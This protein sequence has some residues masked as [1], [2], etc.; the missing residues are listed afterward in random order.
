MWKRSGRR[1]AEPWRIWPPV[2]ALALVGVEALLAV[3]E[4]PRSVLSA[5]AIVVAP[6]LALQPFLPRELGRLGRWLVVPMVGAAAASIAIIFISAIGIPLT[7][8]SLRLLLAVIALG[9]LVVALFVGPEAPGE[10]PGDEWEELDGSDAG[11]R[12]FWRDRT[13]VGAAVGL[14]A[15]LCLAVALQGRVISGSPVPGPDWGSHLLY[16]EQIARQHALLIDNPYW[17]LGGHRFSSDPGVAAIYGAFLIM[18][19]LSATVLAHGIWVF[20]LLSIVAVFVL[21][22]SLWGQG[23]GL[24]AAGVY[25]VMPLNHN[26]LGWHGLANMYALCLLPLTLLAAGW[27]LRGR[28][29]ARWSVLMALTLV[30]LAAGHRL[31]FLLAC[32]AVAIIA[33]VGLVTTPGR[34]ALLRFGLRTAAFA[35]PLVALVAI[36]LATRSSDSG[37]FQSYEIYLVTKV[38]WGL[39]V[40]DLTWPVTVAA[41]LGAIV[42]AVRSRR[43]PACLVLLGLAAATVVLAYGWLLHLPTVYYRMVYYLP[44]AMAPAVGV[45]LA[46]FAGAELRWLRRQVAPAAVAGV[47]GL[48]LVFATS[49]VAYDRGPVVRSFYAWASNASVRGL[50]Q[51]DRRSGPHE[52]VVA[53]RCWGFLAEWLLHR[54]VLAGFDPADILPAWEARPAAQARTILQ[55]PSGPARRMATRK[56]I[57][58]ALV[59]PGCAS[60]QTN[61]VRLPSI[62]VPVYESTRLV[63]LDLDATRPSGAGRGTRRRPPQSRQVGPRGQGR[64]PH[65]DPGGH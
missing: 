23:A 30:A 46:R 27:A 58:F 16:P 51:I 26:M 47:V 52:A 13:Q 65:S 55:A 59:N 54:P 11:A 41:A 61:G 36:D 40:G 6:G 64:G 2:A 15:I 38:Q 24:A 10:P 37:G 60:D 62:G 29:S 12:P 18:S 31:T 35:V 33:V 32:F 21:T 43:D 8:L 34:L 45:A 44:L 3:G 22:S 25:A 7:G 49:A 14:A 56:R 50:E 1:A 28:G 17:M 53:D 39:T 42:L 48:A 63:I 57:R 5:L 9:G 19:G 4:A 20:A